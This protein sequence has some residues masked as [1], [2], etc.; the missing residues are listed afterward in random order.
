MVCHCIQDESGGHLHECKWCEIRCQTFISS[1]RI[2]NQ[3]ALQ[4]IGRFPSRPDPVFAI[5]S[6]SI[7]RTPRLL[8]YK[9]NYP[10]PEILKH[11]DLHPEVAH[12]SI[13]QLQELHTRYLA[14]EKLPVL[15]SE[16]SVQSTRNSLEVL[17]P[18]IY[19]DARCPAC[20]DLLQQRWKTKTGG[21]SAPFCKPCNHV[22][23]LSCSCK[24]CVWPRHLPATAEPRHGVH[25]NLSGHQF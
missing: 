6:V 19:I 16:Y 23:T 9:K 22:E 25:L 15:F 13:S 4:L 24:V 17:L 18:L 12:L 1:A 21:D 8:A 3:K 10:M 14:G 2:K 20:G 11:A 5:G 7:F